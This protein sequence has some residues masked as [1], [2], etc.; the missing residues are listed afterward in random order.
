MFWGL[1][2]FFCFLG[3]LPQHMKVPRL[4]VKSELQL[5]A[6]TTTTATWDPSC[7]CNLH[8]SSRQ[9][10]IPNPLSKAGIESTS[11]WM[12]VR[13][14]STE[15]QW[16]LQGLRFNEELV[17]GIMLGTLYNLSQLILTRIIAGMSQSHLSKNTYLSQLR[18]LEK[19]T[20]YQTAS[21]RI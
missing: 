21:N 4:G 5:Q 8:S 15:S 20:Q 18:Y 2:G 1:L 3:P 14:V 19:S 10:W 9:H 11:S 7:V 6:Y 16:E 12:L 13:F 17:S